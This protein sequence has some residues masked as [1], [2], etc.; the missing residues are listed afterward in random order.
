MVLRCRVW[1]RIVIQQQRHLL[2]RGRPLPYGVQILFGKL[3]KYATDQNLNLS[4]CLRAY[5]LLGALNPVSGKSLMDETT[6]LE[7]HAEGV[8]H[9]Y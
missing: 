6:K 3:Q 9:G 7:Y 4:K 2:D 1:F 5:G 8:L